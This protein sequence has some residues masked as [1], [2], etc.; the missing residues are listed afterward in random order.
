MIAIVA[1]AIVGLMIGMWM[2]MPGRY[3]Q[4]ADEID[5]IMEAGG[6]RRRRTKRI[7]TPMAWVQRHVSAKSSASRGRRESRGRRSGFKL[8]SPDDD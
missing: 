5:K 3:T 1:T 7:F 6:A 4:S 2:G 8:E